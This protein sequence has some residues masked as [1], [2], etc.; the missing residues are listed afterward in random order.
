MAREDRSLS[1][2]IAQPSLDDPLLAQGHRYAFFQAL[3]LLRLR[4][5]D[6]QAFSQ[7]VRVRPSVTLSFPD[8]DIEQIERDAEGKYRITAN[9]F[10]LYGVTSPLPTFYTE[11]LIEEHLQGGSTARDF[12]DILH[13]ALY[14]LLFRAWE[15]NRIWLAVAERQDSTRMEHLYALVGMAG[16][17]A[18]HHPKARGL[19]PHAGNFNQFPRSALGLESLVEGLLEA[20]PVDVE[21]CVAE[22]VS[23]PEPARCLLSEQACVLGED[24]MLGSQI[25]ERAGGLVVHIGPIPG[26]RL[27]DLLPGAA[28]HDRL[29]RAVALYLRAPLRCVLGLRVEPEQRLGACLGEGWCQLGLNTWLP[30]I[31]PGDLAN[32]WPRYD[33]I[34]LPIDTDPTRISKEVLQ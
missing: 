25:A 15:K 31:K 14:P 8:R 17:A 22:I 11:D 19:L 21:P 32:P 7:N 6:I 1:P 16:G 28:L 23:I 9:F 18:A 34:F 27:H 30:E 26:D 33:E 2:A 24:A 12:I 4:S 3:R 29:V 10:G 13:A 5:A 20:L